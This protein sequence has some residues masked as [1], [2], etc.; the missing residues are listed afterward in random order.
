MLIWVYTA[1]SFICWEI[2][3]SRCNCIFHGSVPSPEYT[4]EKA[5]WAAAEFFKVNGSQEGSSTPFSNLVVSH[6]HF[7]EPP[8][9]ELSRQILMVLGQAILF[10]LDWELSSAHPTG[11]LLMEFPPLA[12][13]HPLFKLRPRQLFLPS[14][15]QRIATLAMWFL[16]PTRW[17]LTEA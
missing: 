14:V 3:K 2:W 15:Q 1:A 12:Y 7:W 11:L 17:S 8:L 5:S 13:L 9:L 16:N 4:A 6:P 10:S